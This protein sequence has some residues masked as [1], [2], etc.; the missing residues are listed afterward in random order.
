MV[1]VMPQEYLPGNG[2]KDTGVAMTGG[3][4]TGY[5]AVADVELRGN[6]GQS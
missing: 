6:K 3:Q 2:M 1:P 5:N 4:R